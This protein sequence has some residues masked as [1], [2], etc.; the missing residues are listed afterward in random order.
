MLVFVIVTNR[1]T[2]Q[3]RALMRN[4]ARSYFFELKKEVVI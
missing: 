4:L 2:R 1:L 3:L